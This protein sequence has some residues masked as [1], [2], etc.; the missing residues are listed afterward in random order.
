MPY[1]RLHYH[2]VWATYHREPL[3]EEQAQ[4]LISAVAQTKAGTLRI[5]VH[6]IGFMPDH[7]H[8]AVSIPPAL[9]VA[10]CVRH[11]KGAS[12]RRING[13]FRAFAWQAEY[14]AISVGERSL[15]RVIDY[16]LRQAEHHSSGSTIAALERTTWPTRP[17]YPGGSSPLQRT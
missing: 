1:W 13:D 5:V 10:D 3:L 14:G 16:V 6:A 2:L 7:V 15:P 12:S 9:S 17:P 4:Q 11:F 8:L